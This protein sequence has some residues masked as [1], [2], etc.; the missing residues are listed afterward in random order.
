MIPS[1]KPNQLRDALARILENENGVREQGG[2][3]RGKRVVEYQR[4]TWL[5]PD[6]WPWCAAFICWGVRE[7]L[8]APAVLKALNMT[9][10]QAEQWRPKTAAAFGF[11]EWARKHGMTVLGESE[12]IRR[13]DLYTMDISH[14]GLCVRDAARDEPIKGVEG[15]TSP[16]GSREGGGVYLMQRK[17]RSVIRAIIR[18][19]E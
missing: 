14:I 3:N 6:A 1:M 12:A 16:A 17:P 18:I 8:K 9:A 15:N 4:A 2:N 10:A 19:V 7:W 11:E 13:G 5:E